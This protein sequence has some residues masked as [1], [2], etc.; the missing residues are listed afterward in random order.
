MKNIVVVA[1]DG[2]KWEFSHPAHSY[3]IDED[4]VIIW[5]ERNTVKL[6]LNIELFA[7]LEMEEIK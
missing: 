5:G 1:K 4:V 2:K 6:I 3:R 7:Y